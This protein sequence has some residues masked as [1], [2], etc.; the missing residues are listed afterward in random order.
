MEDEESEIEGKKER[1]I[2]RKLKKTNKLPWPRLI[3]INKIRK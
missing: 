1:D 3:K 2:V